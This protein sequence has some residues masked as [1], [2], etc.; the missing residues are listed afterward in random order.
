MFCVPIGTRVDPAS[1]FHKRLQLRWGHLAMS[2]VPQCT[3]PFADC[4][5]IGVV[6]TSAADD[7]SKWIRLLIEWKLRKF[8]RVP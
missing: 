7:G 4:F 6:V 5:A 2:D 1:F 8:K 3:R